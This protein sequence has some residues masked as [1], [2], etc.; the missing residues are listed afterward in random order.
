[1]T[2][3]TP[4]PDEGAP[5]FRD[6]TTK[7]PCPRRGRSLCTIEDPEHLHSAIHMDAPARAVSDER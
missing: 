6:L 3:Y 2:E 1:M 4:T 5:F 7:A